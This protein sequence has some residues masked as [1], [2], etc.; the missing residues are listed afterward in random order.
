MNTFGRIVTL[1]L[2]FA[3][4]FFGGKDFMPNIMTENAVGGFVV[5]FFLWSVASGS[6]MSFPRYVSQESQWGTLEQV[7][8]SKFDFGLIAAAEL[9]VSIMVSLIFGGILLVLMLITTGVSIN[10]DLITVIPI[11]L[12]TVCSGIGLGFILGGITLIYKRIENL[13]GIINIG[14]IGLIAAPGDKYT[15]VNVLPLSLGSELLQ[16]T[17][18][19]DMEL[20]EIPS[21]LLLA[22][23]AKAI[24]YIL[25]GYGIYKLAEK[26]SRKKG[27][28]S[29][30]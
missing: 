15:P 11:L 25:V 12:L 27:S 9:I 13:L 1:Y 20:W 29:D 26:Y 7:Y 3:M 17:M 16:L 6:V 2:F 23:V 21:I 14:V 4:F 24:L 10:L 22:L 8:L 5:G 18:N 30:Y 28:M 19:N